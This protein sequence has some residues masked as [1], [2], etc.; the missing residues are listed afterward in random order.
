MVVCFKSLPS[1]IQIK[2]NE[3]ESKSIKEINFYH[4][5]D[6]VEVIIVGTDLAEKPFCKMFYFNKEDANDDNR[7]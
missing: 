7:S 3:S 2:I 4:H 5:K 1:N 6:Y